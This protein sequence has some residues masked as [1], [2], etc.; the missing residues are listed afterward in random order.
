MRRHP[1]SL[2]QSRAPGAGST[3]MLWMREIEQCSPMKWCCD[4]CYPYASPVYVCVEVGSA[5]ERSTL[6]FGCD[7]T[8]LAECITE[9]LLKFRV[10]YCHTEYNG[11]ALCLCIALCFYSISKLMISY[12]FVIINITLFPGNLNMRPLATHPKGT[13]TIVS[14][15]YF[16]HKAATA[17]IHQL[18]KILTW[19][20]AFQCA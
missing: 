1:E 10:R 19:L 4:G 6:W 13:A 16:M 3:G 5:S 15:S 11:V 9:R 18:A 12:V 20:L 2:S 8:G 7:W 17:P 14:L